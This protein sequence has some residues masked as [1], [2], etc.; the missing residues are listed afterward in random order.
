[1]KN[2]RITNVANTLGEH[3]HQDQRP[4]RV[5]Q[6]EP[7]EHLEQRHDGHLGR[8]QQAQQH[9]HEQGVG[10]GETHAGEGVAGQR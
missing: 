2:W 8:Y 10:A 5:D 4:V 6:A 9:H 1:M 7:A 3:R